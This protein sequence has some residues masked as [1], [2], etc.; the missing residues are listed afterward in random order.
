MVMNQSLM[1]AQVHGLLYDIMTLIIN[2][3]NGLNYGKKKN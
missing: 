1:Q 2:N 3:L